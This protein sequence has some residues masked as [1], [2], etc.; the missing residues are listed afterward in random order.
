MQ[1]QQAAVSSSSSSGTGGKPF[2][3]PLD[4]KALKSG[5]GKSN[6]KVEFGEFKLQS[7]NLARVDE[8]VELQ[9]GF[10]VREVRKQD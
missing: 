10:A 9:P 6:S 7:Q 1:F 3:P 2:V 8:S 4:L 5:N